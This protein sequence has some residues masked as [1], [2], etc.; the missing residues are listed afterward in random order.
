MNLNHRRWRELAARRLKLARANGE[1]C[2]ICG[3]ALD[4]TAKPGTRR[5]PTVDHLIP[6]SLGGE[7]LAPLHHLAPACLSCNASRGN[8]TRATKP[9]TP[10][11]RDW[12]TK[13]A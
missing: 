6:R 11:S 8:G 4:W 3:R 10:T 5:Y 9:P 13:P 12:W 2:H 1:P 7:T